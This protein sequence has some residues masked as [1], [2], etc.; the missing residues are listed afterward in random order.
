MTSKIPQ[1]TKNMLLLFS[2]SL[3]FSTVSFSLSGDDT[4]IDPNAPVNDG[5]YFLILIASVWFSYQLV[6]DNKD[7]KKEKGTT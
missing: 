1:Q 4:D 3:L 2:F 7:E 5:I 6:R